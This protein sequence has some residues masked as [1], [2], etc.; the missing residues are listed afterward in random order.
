M[1]LQYF[2]L[3]LS[4]LFFAACGGGNSTGGAGT[5]T[6]ANANSHLK[7]V[8]GLTATDLPTNAGFG[9]KQYIKM[10]A[11]GGAVWLFEYAEEGKKISSSKKTSFQFAEIDKDL[12]NG[13]TIQKAESSPI[14]QYETYYF[15]LSGKNLKEFFV[16][17]TYQNNELKKK[18]INV[19]GFNFRDE[20]TATAALKEIQAGV[21]TANQ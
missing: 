14:M 19:A 9:T 10:D 17:E 1:K 15:S 16:E 2:F 6:D 8:E 4:S 11:R 18:N 12:L 20:A 5:T 13:Q 3:L 7:E 21:A